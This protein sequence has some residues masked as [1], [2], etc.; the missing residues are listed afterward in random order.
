MVHDHVGF[1]FRTMES[2][3]DNLM[4]ADVAGEDLV[5]VFRI[6]STEAPDVV[7]LARPATFF[8][9]SADG[10]V[11]T[12]EVPAVLVFTFADLCVLIEEFFVFHEL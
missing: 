11:V 1:G 4:N 9:K 12:G 10:P 6:L 7:K 8:G 5:A 3:A 2:S